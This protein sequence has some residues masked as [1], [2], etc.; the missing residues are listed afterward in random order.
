MQ[1]RN[2]ENV[3]ANGRKALAVTIEEDDGVRREALFTSDLKR[4]ILDNHN[5]VFLGN[6]F[7]EDYEVTLPEDRA[8]NR[9]KTVLKGFSNDVK[10]V[11][12][13]REWLRSLQR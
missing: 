7:L 4:T 10:I 5:A 3:D 11:E 2:V 6:E 13:V 9:G 12:L 8:D 1:I